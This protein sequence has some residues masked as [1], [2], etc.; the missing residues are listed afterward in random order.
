LHLHVDCDIGGQNL[1]QGRHAPERI[2][3]L[4]FRGLSELHLRGDLF[5]A[6][7]KAQQVEV[8]LPTAVGAV[9]A[10]VAAPDVESQLHARLHVALAHAQLGAL[11]RHG[12]PLGQLQHDPATSGLQTTDAS[13]SVSGSGRHV[14]HAALQRRGRL[15]Q[16]ARRDLGTQ[17]WLSGSALC[18]GCCSCR[19]LGDSTCDCESRRIGSRQSVALAVRWCFIL[20][21]HHDSRPLHRRRDGLPFAELEPNC[22]D[23]NLY[24]CVERRLLRQLPSSRRDA[25][26]AQLAQRQR[27][28]F[29][30]QRKAVALRQRLQPSH[31]EG[32]DYV[33][34]K[35]AQRHDATAQSDKGKPQ[36]RQ[37]F[38]S[39]R[40]DSI[41][42][43]CPLSFLSSSLC[44]LFSPRQ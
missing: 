14:H 42:L 18:A 28:Q 5:D 10:R 19:S 38:D 43:H 17:R 36:R 33:C 35:S 29:Q 32:V 44:S 1:E 8:D 37:R 34:E 41:A 30:R 7:R 25:H 13:G 40:F 20:E 11:Q 24:G 4:V 6:H 21:Q 27:A 2:L 3:R 39:I 9:C 16:T 26:V 15:R 22:I 23:C 31:Q 12:H